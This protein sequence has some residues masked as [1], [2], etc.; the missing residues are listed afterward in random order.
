MIA[1]HYPEI[2]ADDDYGDV[3]GPAGEAAGSVLEGRAQVGREVMCVQ[4]GRAGLEGRGYL[5]L[6][7]HADDMP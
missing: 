1:R 5:V 6:E 3:H 2:P 4:D 7:R